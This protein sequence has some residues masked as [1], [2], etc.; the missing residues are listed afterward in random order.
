MVAIFLI[1]YIFFIL[2]FFFV[3]VV[4]S[5]EKNFLY[6]QLKTNVFHEFKDNFSLFT[7]IVFNVRGTF[8]MCLGIGKNLSFIFFTFLHW[9]IIEIY[10]FVTPRSHCFNR[11]CQKLII[12]IDYWLIFRSFLFCLNFCSGSSFSIRCVDIRHTL[13]PIQDI[14]LSTNW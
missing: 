2:Y 13:N 9:I 5:F 10:C 12:F 11:K 6:K 14:D 8:F 1:Y 7:F 3:I 4:Y